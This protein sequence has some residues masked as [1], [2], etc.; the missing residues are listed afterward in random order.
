MT[1]PALTHV[2]RAQ[3]QGPLRSACR[4]RPGGSAPAG[5]LKGSPVAKN[6]PF[7]PARPGPAGSQCVTWDHMRADRS[8]RWSTSPHSGSPTSEPSSTTCRRRRCTRRR[9]AAA[10][11]PSATWARSSSGPASTRGARPTT[12]SWSASRRARTRSGGAS[13]TSRSSP[14]TSSCSK[15]AA[16][17]PPGAR[18]LRPG[19]LRGS[20]SRVPPADPGHH[21]DRL[22]QPVRPRHV[23]SRVRPGGPGALRARV[24]RHRLPPASTPSPSVDGTRSEAFILLNFG[25][26]LVIIGGTST[27]ARSRSRC[28]P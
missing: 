28:S 2:T 5:R 25:Q 23:H 18:R 8:Q 4:P 16:G 27:R 24:H 13:S 12:S 1:S 15:P 7:G 3:V 17:V 9:S 26:R 6:G 22:A 21:R 10:R 19:L 11:G 14:S 20:R